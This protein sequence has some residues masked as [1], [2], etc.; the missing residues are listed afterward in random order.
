MKRNILAASIRFALK[1]WLL[2]MRGIPLMTLEQAR[3][4]AEHGD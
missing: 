2:D 1:F 3:N 4:A